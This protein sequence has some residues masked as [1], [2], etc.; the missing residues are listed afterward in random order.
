MQFFKYQGTG[1]DFIMVDNRDMQFKKSQNEI[2]KMCNRN[3]GV[4]ADGL[5]L[6]QN[7]KGYDFEMVYYNSDGNPSS[8]CGNGGRCI[9]AFAGSL[10]IIKHKAH[11]I[12]TDGEHFAD[13]NNDNVKL[14]MQDVHEVKVYDE[15]NYF[16]NTGSPHHIS[17]IAGLEKFDV[18]NKGREVRNSSRY[19]PS[20]SNANF[21]EFSDGEL[22]VRT[23]ERGVEAETLSCGTGVTAVALS[24]A[25]KNLVNGNSVNI[26]TIGGKLTVHF[27][28][29]GNDSFN[30]IWLEGPAKQ[31]FKGEIED[32]T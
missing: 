13:I 24:A 21:V 9:T 25:F 6:L 5:I 7:K 31:V 20:G 16:I 28:R 18:F 22:N 1:N 2:E 14:K 30:N 27:N 26:H 12:A 3:F 15:Q 23:Y 29:T 10:G 8:M 19:T 4:G 17:Y 32:L 11:F